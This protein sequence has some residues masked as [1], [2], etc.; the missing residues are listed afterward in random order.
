MKAKTKE[1]EVQNQFLK[2]VLIKKLNLQDIPLADNMKVYSITTKS[3]IQRISVLIP[4][5]FD[6]IIFY[7]EVDADHAPYEN[8]KKK[9]LT[10]IRIQRERIQLLK[11]DYWEFARALAAPQMAMKIRYE[12]E[13]L[14]NKNGIKT[15]NYAQNRFNTAQKSEYEELREIMLTKNLS[16]KIEN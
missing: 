10:A 13:L 7:A 12:E 15:L 4:F 2:K 11:D 14:L 3:N 6:K 1:N 5:E 8:L 16:K 9:I